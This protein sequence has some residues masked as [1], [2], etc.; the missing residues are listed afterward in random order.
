VATSKRWRDLKRGIGLLRKHFLPDPFDPL[1]TYPQP[2]RIQAQT[3]GYLVLCHA[4]IE[5]YLEDWAK[6]I[7]R[8]TEI[9]WSSSRTVTEP[10]A[11]LLATN[12]ERLDVPNSLA[13]ANT[14]DS[15][16]RLAEATVKLFQKFYKQVNDNNGI[17]ERNVLALFCP[18]GIPATAL[19]TTLLP[20]LDSLG[21]IRG[22]Y[23]HR[24]AKAVP[25]VLDP[26]TEYNKITALIGDL[27]V[28][29]DWLVK[30][31]RR[32]R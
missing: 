15:P 5:S 17:K 22:T 11:F 20:N 24:S 18:L 14:K 30:Y 4:E 10:L 16:Q 27:V 21:R 3:R 8:A 7:A 28:L 26:Q 9:V 1:G 2:D 29:D 12:S 31:R 25:N 32:I 19:G 23:A 13:G 6:E